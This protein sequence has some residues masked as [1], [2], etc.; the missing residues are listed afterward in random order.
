MSGTDIMKDDYTLSKKLS[1]TE[2]SSNL[3]LREHYLQHCYLCN[4][5][6]VVESPHLQ[7][8]DMDSGKP[9]STSHAYMDKV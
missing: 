2:M 1:L 6:R 3:M 8:K 4:Y 5:Q 9:K 7:R